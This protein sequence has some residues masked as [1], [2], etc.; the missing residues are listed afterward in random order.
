LGPG[1]RRQ[2]LDQ[3][4]T[5]GAAVRIPEAFFVVSMAWLLGLKDS[6][7]SLPVYP[8]S[9]LVTGAIALLMKRPD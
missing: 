9:A 5:P 4:R 8:I 2:A 3:F 6:D 7:Q 1:E